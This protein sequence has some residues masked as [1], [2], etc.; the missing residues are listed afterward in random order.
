[1]ISR[2][3]QVLRARGV[4]GAL[5]MLAH[6]HPDRMAEKFPVFREKAGTHEPGSLWLVSR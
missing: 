3:L 6:R 5:N 2:L 1:M 4:I